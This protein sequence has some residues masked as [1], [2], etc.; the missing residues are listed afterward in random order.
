MLAVIS[1]FIFS[2]KKS[3]VN[4]LNAAALKVIAVFPVAN[5]FALAKPPPKEWPTKDNSFPNFP[6]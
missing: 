2:D 6:I 5:A 1:A 4:G 3:F